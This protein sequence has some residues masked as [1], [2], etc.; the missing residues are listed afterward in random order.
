MSLVRARQVQNLRTKLLP[1]ERTVASLP[2][3]PKIEYP[4]TTAGYNVSKDTPS[5]GRCESTIYT[6][7]LFVGPEHLIL[8]AHPNITS[9]PII[10]TNTADTTPSAYQVV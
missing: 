7:I 6:T 3:Q 2:P 4:S 8:P 9:P 5:S 1:R 10:R